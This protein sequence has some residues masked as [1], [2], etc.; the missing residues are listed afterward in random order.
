MNDKA[1][2]AIRAVALILA[3][4]AIACGIYLHR[5]R[6]IRVADLFSDEYRYSF[7]LYRSGIFGTGEGSLDVST[8]LDDAEIRG[9]LNKYEVRRSHRQDGAVVPGVGYFELAL[10][11]AGENPRA[12]LMVFGD[13]RVWA[14]LC[15]GHGYT[16]YEISNGQD[17]TL[18]AELTRRYREGAA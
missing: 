4:A 14:D 17:D 2:W 7:F 1:K 13:G 5:Y 10:E 8:A 16:E 18:F 15:T 3:I 9:I 11:T 6:P 12:W